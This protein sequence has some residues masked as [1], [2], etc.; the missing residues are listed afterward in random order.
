M[1]AEAAAAP[2]LPTE[3]RRLA[4]ALSFGV[5]LL[6]LSQEI[7]WVRVVAL[8]QSGRPQA[9]AQVLAVFLLGIA[10]GA[11]LGRRACARPGPLWPAAGVLLLRAA[12]FDLAALWLCGQPF[13]G[14]LAPSAYLPVALCLAGGGALLKGLLFPVVHHLGST[15][16]AAGVGR[17]VSRVYLANVAGSTMGP[18]LVGFWLLDHA[19]LERAFAL[20]AL[21]TALLGGLALL[22]SGRV[23]TAAPLRLAAVLLPLL[24]VVG[25]AWPPAVVLQIVGGGT[26]ERVRHLVQN[27]HGVLHV[28]AEDTPG[29]GDITFGG[30]A[31]DG[32]IGVDMTV[33][34]NGLDRVYL[35][36]ALHPRPRRV[37]VIGLSTGAWVTAVLGMPGVEQLDVVEINPGYL[38]LIARY[39]A[40]APL[41]DDKRLRIH[42][43]DG[44]RWLRARLA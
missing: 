38:S 2:A 24:A 11:L 27:K 29:S 22:R 6:S 3:Q 18:L 5:G 25:V 30:N 20:V 19:P 4:W 28:L 32:R 13:I 39:P 14:A 36:A 35:L 16:T 7:L 37:L 17:S 31:Y 21:G 26:P 41:L 15:P 33:N 12:A 10:L 23:A 34:A 42:I 40:V 44:R 8:S 43:D 1:A 9:F